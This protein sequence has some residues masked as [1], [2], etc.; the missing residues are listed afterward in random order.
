MGYILDV[1][2]IGIIVFIVIISAKKGFI[3]GTKSILSLVI[4]VILLSSLQGSMLD[5]LQKTAFG[6]GV[7]KT[8]TK[9]V[10]KVY[11][12]EKFSADADTTDTEQALVICNAM[13]LP[14]FWADSLEDEIVSFSEIQKNVMEVITDA[15][16]QMIMRIVAFVLLLIMVRVFAFLAIMLLETLFHLPILKTINR[17]LGAIIGIFNALLIIYIICG[18]VGAFVPAD[19]ISSVTEVMDNTILVK[20]FYN[21]NLLLTLFI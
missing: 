16:T 17:S 21:N 11:K 6:E 3:S 5:S 18:V 4:T 12:T 14:A 7:R 9:N 1:I 15:I 20:H 8:V 2:L 13:S 19:Q 10:E